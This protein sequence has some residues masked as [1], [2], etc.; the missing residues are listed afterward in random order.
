L[1]MAIILTIVYSLLIAV[2]GIRLV[3][4]KPGDTMSVFMEPNHLQQIFSTL[5]P[6]F[7][8]FWSLLRGALM[9]VIVILLIRWFLS[10]GGGRV[11]GNVSGL[12]S[13]VPSL[14]A[15]L[16][17]GTVSIITILG[18]LIPDPLGNIALV[19]VGFY[20]GQERERR[21]ASRRQ[22]ATEGND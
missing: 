6:L 13:D 21:S 15:V 4:F 18:I 2:S 14:I 17:I 8:D 11:S 1:I 7:T 20:F 5:T 3:F 16:V 9:L 10:V 22:V 19:I 12:L